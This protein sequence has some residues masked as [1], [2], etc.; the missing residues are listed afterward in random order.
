MQSVPFNSTAVLNRACKGFQ[1]INR[2]R[3]KKKKTDHDVK[4]KHNVDKFLKAVQL[5]KKTPSSQ[6]LP[7]QQF[8]DYL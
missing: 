1:L 4:Q 3:K 8:I 5:W 7:V 2:A 6:K